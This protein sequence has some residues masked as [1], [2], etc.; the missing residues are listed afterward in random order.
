MTDEGK[1]LL[2]LQLHLKMAKYFRFKLT[3]KIKSSMLNV[4]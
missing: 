3:I 4:A 1:R 2:F